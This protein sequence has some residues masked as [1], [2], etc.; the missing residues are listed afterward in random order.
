MLAI[1]DRST[2][3][4]CFIAL[5]LAWIKYCLNLEYR[6]DLVLWD[7]AY[8]VSGAR[9][10]DLS[11]LPSANW[12]PFYSLWYRF[13]NLFDTNPV[14][15]YYINIRL[16]S[17]FISLG[18]FLFLKKSNVNIIVSFIIGIFL[19]VSD[20]NLLT[21]PKP[22]HLGL[23]FFLLMIASVADKKS[24]H[25]QFIVFLFAELFVSYIRAEYL[26][27]FIG[28]IVFV[29]LYMILKR[30][31]PN[32]N[33]IIGYSFLLL[34]LILFFNFFGI[35]I[36]TSSD[37]SIV[38]FGQYFAL[39][40]CQWTGSQLLPLFD[41]EIIFREN[42]GSSETIGQ[43]FLANP[44]F[45]ARHLLQNFKDF[46]LEWR[47]LFYPSIWGMPEQSKKYVAFAIIMGVIFL[48]WFKRK[49]LLFNFKTEFLK[50]SLLFI[51]AAPALVSCILFS[52][53]KHYIILIAMLYTLILCLL[54]FSN[55]NSNNSIDNK[56]TWAG[57][58]LWLFVPYVESSNK[59]PENH[60]VVKYVS[61]HFSNSEKTVLLESGAGVGF[62]VKGVT[63]VP[64]ANIKPPFMKSIIENNIN[65]VVVDYYF[66]K[67]PFYRD[68]PS[69]K[70][71]L[72]DSLTMSGFK[73]VR[74]LN[75]LIFERNSIK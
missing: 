25:T 34:S 53:R 7:E 41:W 13:L 51:A 66:D 27:G 17:L 45:F 59:L 72:S 8:Y 49:S 22:S 43:A 47:F 12:A 30:A 50:I 60:Q 73:K 70:Y 75:T 65:V 1:D 54:L 42:F 32:K 64:V 69:W 26:L 56:W 18:G 44:S 63:W 11:S 71:V 58:I 23:G 28:T 33:E 24:F 19:L 14:N 36:F 48:I 35:P 5:L 4:M 3:F 2:Y 37:R 46:I 6:V 31:W 67:M 57:I 68:N 21:V 38:A 9:Y 55:S 62:Y 74:I 40:W 39:H 29:L 20:L 10:L 16:S 61:D 15:L 52:P